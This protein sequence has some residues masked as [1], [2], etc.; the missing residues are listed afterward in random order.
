MKLKFIGAFCALLCLITVFAAG[1][2]DS[3]EHSEGSVSGTWVTKSS[4]FADDKNSSGEFYYTFDEDDKISV[5]AGTFSYVG[6]WY[7]VD[8]DGKKIDS[9]ED[10]IK[11]E[12]PTIISG[13]FAAEVKAE[14]DDKYT[15]KLTDD[16]DK[17]MTL[18]SAEL[19][20][21]KNK[22]ADDFEEVDYITGTW[23]SVD[24]D[25]VIYTFNSDGTCKISQESLS[26]EGSYKVNEKD[27]IIEITYL[28][29]DKQNTLNI[30]F[31]VKDNE[32]GEKITFA[33]SVFKKV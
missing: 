30:P 32:K 14:S 19:P 20:E 28:E 10:K 4:V 15:L 24:S 13:V 8:E 18:N 3:S 6:K 11:I 23:Q 17:T 12:V 22:V 25:E 21:I 1:C 26:I 29:Q 9:L 16:N 5:T 7:Y 27:K 31:L 33:D 2:G